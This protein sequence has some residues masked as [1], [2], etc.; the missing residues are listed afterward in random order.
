MRDDPDFSKRL[1]KKVQAIKEDKQHIS[2]VAQEYETKYR[3][4]I[5][6]GTKKCA[7]LLQEGKSRGL[8]EDQVMQEYGRFIPTVRTPIPVSYTHLTLPT[9]RIV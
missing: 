1:G 6:E 8:S 3:E 9:K 2:S 4:E 5:I 7:L